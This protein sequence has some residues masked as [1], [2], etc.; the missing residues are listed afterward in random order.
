MNN[1]T[2]SD[3]F[4]DILEESK[5]L[6]TIIKIEKEVSDF[7]SD[8]YVFFFIVKHCL[9]SYLFG[10]ITNSTGENLMN[11]YCEYD[12]YI[13]QLKTEGNFNEL[14]IENIE[15]VIKDTSI[16]SYY[17]EI[18]SSLFLAESN[19]NEI[20]LINIINNEECNSFIEII[21]EDMYKLSKYKLE[22]NIIK[23]LE[24]LINIEVSKMNSK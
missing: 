11:Y 10:F 2:F 23:N 13:E 4:E 14:D 16:I 8:I 19:N 7:S 24:L 17:S 3:L 20:F 6:S 5:K 18:H 22:T 12:K 9:K 21:P 1:E 15:K